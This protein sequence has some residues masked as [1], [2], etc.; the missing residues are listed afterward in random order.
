MRAA[1]L[2]STT[3][4]R[5]HSPKRFSRVSVSLWLIFC[6][7]ALAGLLRAPSA[8]TQDHTRPR[9]TAQSFDTQKPS[10]TPTQKP[11]AAKPQDSA[12]DDDDDEVVTINASEVLLPVTVRDSSGALVTD[13]ARKD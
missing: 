13:L 7:C 8:F 11:D 3:E 1:K 12:D 5:R 4:T 10:G 6:C 2:K 9:R